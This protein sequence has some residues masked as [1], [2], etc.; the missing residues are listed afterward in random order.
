MGKY[1][2]AGNWKMNKSVPETELLCNEILKLIPI[3]THTDVVLCP[4]FTSLSTAASILS[5]VIQLGAQ[6]LYPE[7]S[8]AFTGE[9][10]PEMISTTG[11]THV[12]LG[13]SE[14]RAI[15]QESNQFINA[16]IIA[17][18]GHGLISIV[19]VGETEG[20]RENNTTNNVIS[21]QVK[22]GLRDISNP[23]IIL[24]YE[25]V[26]A[27]GTGK[28]ATPQMAQEVHALI[29]KLLVEKFGPEGKTI[30]ILYGSSMKPENA[31]EL[32]KYN[33]IDGGL[34]GIVELTMAIQRVFD[35]PRDQVMFD[36]SHQ[37]YP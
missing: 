2:I 22:E 6:N 7:K 29:R 18:L 23:N 21:T 17:A 1:L 5:K 9:I 26:W 27:I 25:P 11:A 19:C 36:V 32:L 31:S 30:K 37:C 16:K 14:R 35:S 20:E 15:F 34:I 12:I 4:L 8:G 13:H 33:D 24:A 3:A 28:T 10:S